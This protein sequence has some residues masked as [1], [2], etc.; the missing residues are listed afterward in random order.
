M[1]IIRISAILS[2]SGASIYVQWDWCTEK[3]SICATQSATRNKVVANVPLREQAD[4]QLV[5][6]KQTDCNWL[7]GTRYQS[8]PFHGQSKNF[9]KLP[10][11]PNAMTT[12]Y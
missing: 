4:C 6:A 9:C 11:V 10:A 2:A 1:V 8:T 7:R 3:V 12:N 5:S